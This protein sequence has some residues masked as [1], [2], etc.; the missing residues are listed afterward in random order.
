MYG[1]CPE[2][3]RVPTCAELEELSQ[4]HSEWT[5]NENSQSGYWFSGSLSYSSE[6]AQVFFPAAGYRDYYDGE[7]NGRGPYGHYWSSSPRPLYY[8][9]CYL[10]FESGDAGKHSDPSAYGY[11]VRCVQE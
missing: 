2:G 1:P 10:R 7:A 3:W 8:S 9:Y 6:V 11:S 4:N 5:I